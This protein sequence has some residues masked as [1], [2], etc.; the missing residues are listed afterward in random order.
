MR[1]KEMQE[2]MVKTIMKLYQKAST[3]IKVGRIKVGSSYSDKFPV[4]VGVHQ[5][6]VLLFFL[7]ATMI[8]VIMK[9]VRKGLFH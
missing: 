8:D 7:F 5:E 1:K 3:R 2:V 9:K 4:R 6:S